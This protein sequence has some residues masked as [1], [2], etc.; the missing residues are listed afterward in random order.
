MLAEHKSLGRDLGKAHA[1]AIDYIQDLGRE[2][3]G[4]EVP[5][6]VIVSDFARI[7]LH[8]LEADTSVENMPKGNYLLI[9]E[10]SSQRRTYIPSGVHGPRRAL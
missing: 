9:P 3:R 6:Y 4:D 2:G 8:D 1:Q 5:Q 7:A 10:V